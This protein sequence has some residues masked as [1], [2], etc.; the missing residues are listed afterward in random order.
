MRGRSKG[1]KD[2]ETD[3]RGQAIY[4]FTLNEDD[5]N[6]LLEFL[7]GWDGIWAKRLSNLRPDY[8]RVANTIAEQKKEQDALLYPDNYETPRDLARS[9]FH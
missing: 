6:V 4:R 2:P 5:L 1:R 8:I 9:N 3:E 7:H